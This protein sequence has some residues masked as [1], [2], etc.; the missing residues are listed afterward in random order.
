MQR[1]G[2]TETLEGGKGQEIGG[3]VVSLEWQHTANCPQGALTN[4]Q[5]CCLSPQVLGTFVTGN[6]SLPCRLGS[7]GMR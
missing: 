6:G 5:P 3:T 1:G 4:A 7:G 2:Q